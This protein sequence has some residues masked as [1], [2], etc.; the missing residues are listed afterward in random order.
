MSLPKKPDPKIVL[1]LF[2]AGLDT[3]AIARM[4]ASTEPV[5]MRA[6]IEAREA[7]RVAKAYSPFSPE[8]KQALEGQ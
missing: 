6:L 7:S 1:G 4:M 2:K 5:I 3:F 8:R